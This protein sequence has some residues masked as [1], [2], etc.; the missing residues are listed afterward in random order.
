MGRRLKE[1]GSLRFCVTA[2]EQKRRHS[3]A[4]LLQGVK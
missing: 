3:L 2:Q 4:S 1:L